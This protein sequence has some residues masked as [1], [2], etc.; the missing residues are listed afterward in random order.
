MRVFGLLLVETA[1][2]STY[3]VDI[4]FLATIAKTLVWISRN[5]KRILKIQALS[6]LIYGGVPQGALI[7]A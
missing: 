5:P 2:T 4:L 3:C 1:F 6:D 7:L